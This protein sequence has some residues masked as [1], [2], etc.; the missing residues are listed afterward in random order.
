MQIV[1][2]TLRFLQLLCENHN[3]ELQDKIREQEVAPS[4]NVIE[5][6]TRMFGRYL[7]IFH[8]RNLRLGIQLI[9]TMIE[10]IQGP[11]KANQ[12]K[13]VEDKVV[14]HVRDI[15]FFMRKDENLTK[16]GIKKD[17]DDE[18]ISFNTKVMI[19]LTSLLEGNS[20]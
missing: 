16:K 7:K 9:T 15:M 11:N 14:D 10:A 1:I 8:K 17:D 19:L 18:L 2:R 13:L 12:S 3:H 20:D 5:V 4:V 6:I